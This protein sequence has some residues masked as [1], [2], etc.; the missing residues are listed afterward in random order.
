MLGE[1]FRYQGFVCG[2]V[3]VCLR[4]RRKTEGLVCLDRVKDNAVVEMQG[5]CCGWWHG[6]AVIVVAAVI[7]RIYLFESVEELHGRRNSRESTV[8]WQ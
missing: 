1:Y 7:D 6:I 3:C 5:C 2:L 4:R 8:Y